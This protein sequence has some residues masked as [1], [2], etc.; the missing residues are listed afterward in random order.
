LSHRY[1]SLWNQVNTIS[2]PPA[3]IMTQNDRRNGIAPALAPSQIDDIEQIGCTPA[4]LTRSIAEVRMMA[5]INSDSGIQRGRAC[6]GSNGDK[7]TAVRSIGQAVSDQSNYAQLPDTRI[8]STTRASLR[9][10]ILA[11]EESL[12]LTSTPRKQP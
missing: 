4:A 5:G 9:Y 8:L 7:A 10:S 1:E 11:I 3:S 2:T 12:F 6:A